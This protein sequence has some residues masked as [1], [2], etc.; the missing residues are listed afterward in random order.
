VNAELRAEGK[1]SFGHLEGAPAAKTAAIGA[2]G[3]GSAVD[4]P[5][6]HG[7]HG[8]HRLFLN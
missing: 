8:A 2:A 6:L 3:N 1:A 4:P 5:T 7:A